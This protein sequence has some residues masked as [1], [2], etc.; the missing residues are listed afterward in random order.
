M[1]TLSL[2][3]MAILPTLAHADLFEE[4]KKPGSA[5]GAAEAAGPL[6]SGD[7]VETYVEYFRKAFSTG[8]TAAVQRFLGLTGAVRTSKTGT[9][10]C[11]NHSKGIDVKPVAGTTHDFQAV[12]MA[13]SG[14][15]ASKK[16]TH[17]VEFRVRLTPSHV[18]C[19]SDKKVREFFANKDKRTQAGVE[20][21]T[22]MNSV[23]GLCLYT[24]IYTDPFNPVVGFRAVDKEWVDEEL[25]KPERKEFQDYILGKKTR[26][27]QSGKISN[28]NP[29]R[30][31]EKAE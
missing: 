10:R 8:R 7:N 4:M 30:D 22:R 21:F 6:P 3:V 15:V 19:D 14:L 18:D 20:E 26:P 27:G 23:G 29:F 9:A 1:K 11:H 13:H 5:S 31:P 28:D 17:L 2:I 24:P 25:S 16:V 12:C